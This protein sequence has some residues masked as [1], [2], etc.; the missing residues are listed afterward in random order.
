MLN[1]VPQAGQNLQNTRDPIRN[2]FSTIDTAFSVNH[3]SYGASGAGNH[4][5]VNFVEQLSPAPVP[6]GTTATSVALY[7]AAGSVSPNI[8]LWFQGINSATP[9]EISYAQKMVNGYTWL[10]GGILI[11][12]G[13]AQQAANVSDSNFN[14]PLMFPTAA[15]WAMGSPNSP[16]SGSNTDAIISVQVVNQTQGVVQRKTNF[17]TAIGFNFFAIGY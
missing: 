12:W 16:P 7:C 11:Q 2:N 9:V 1:I 6:P 14:W 8:S 5:V 10:P 4:T 13:N 15:L 17:G 3:V